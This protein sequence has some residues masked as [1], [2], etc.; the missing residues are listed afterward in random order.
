MRSRASYAKFRM[1]ASVKAA[2]CC[3]ERALAE[4]ARPR[5]TSAA[6]AW[7]TRELGF[8]KHVVVWV[9]HPK[10]ARQDL[11]GSEAE[12]LRNSTKSEATHLHSSPAAAKGFLLIDLRAIYHVRDRLIPASVT[13]EV[14]GS[15]QGSQAG[16]PPARCWSH[17]H[18]DG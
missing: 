1:S 2:A 8:A 10:H 13:F 18:N 11:R 16:Y 5:T 7:E 9:Q 4:A 15:G 3:R 17:K 12:R 6:T 14:E